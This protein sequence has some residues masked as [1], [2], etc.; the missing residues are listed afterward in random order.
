[1]DSLEEVDDVDKLNRLLLDI[2]TYLM[3][4]D[5]LSLSKWIQGIQTSFAQFY[6][7]SKKIVRTAHEL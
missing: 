4:E 2:G 1:M 3:N 7:A 5:K 6:I